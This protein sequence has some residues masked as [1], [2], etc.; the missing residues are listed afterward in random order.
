MLREIQWTR[1]DP[2][3][4]VSTMI[5]EGGGVSMSLQK[6][7]D[8]LVHSRAQ[9]K[10]HEW[11]NCRTYINKLI[12]MFGENMDIR[13]ITVAGI[14]QM[15]AKLKKEGLAENTLKKFRL[16]IPWLIRVAND[17]EKER[18]ME[19]V[20]KSSSPDGIRNDFRIAWVDEEELPEYLDSPKF[21]KYAD[22][23]E[24]LKQTLKRAKDKKVLRIQ[25]LQD[26]DPK[27]IGSRLTAIHS[28]I[29]TM[30]WWA[31]FS[32]VKKVFIIYRGGPSRK[33]GV[34]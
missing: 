19:T 8:K 2:K 17:I 29:R 31:R 33:G 1:I 16:T 28:G 11:S 23:V 21:S 15:S 10:D 30:G 18:P 34:K 5:V 13:N 4:K 9:L 25:P 20:T 22:F 7:K 32:K 24:Q 12:K 26:S 3:T 14:L 6:L 27:E